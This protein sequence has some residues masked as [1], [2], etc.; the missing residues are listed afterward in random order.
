MPYSLSGVEK[1]SKHDIF[2]SWYQLGEFRHLYYELRKLP[3][4]VLEYNIAL[5]STAAENDNCTYILGF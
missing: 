2:K 5:Q 3:S 1:R 4:K